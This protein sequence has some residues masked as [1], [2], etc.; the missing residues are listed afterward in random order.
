MTKADDYNRGQVERGV[1]TVAHVT[2]LVRFWQN[3]H[4]LTADA[5]AGPLTI[6]SVDRFVRARG[7]LTLPLARCWP[8]RTLVDGRK[9][10][11][12]SAFGAANPERRGHRGADIMYL[13]RADKDPP[14]KIGDSGRTRPRPDGT[15]YW[16]P[17]G[18]E[19]VAQ[20][21]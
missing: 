13:Y 2:E 5:M 8:L 7:E 3:G 10:M 19:V 6:A 17:E 4:Q 18:T 14:T 12:T 20:A 21:D 11:I 9:P 15:S 16:I 1:L